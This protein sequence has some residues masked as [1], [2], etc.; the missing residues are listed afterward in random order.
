M[1]YKSEFG[2][3]AVTEEFVEAF[4]DTTDFS[5]GFFAFMKSSKIL[6]NGV[7]PRDERV[8]EILKRLEEWE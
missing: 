4:K 8:K 1:G 3:V 6:P 2:L 7:D 5:G